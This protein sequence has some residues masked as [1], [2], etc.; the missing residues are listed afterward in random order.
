MSTNIYANSSFS[1]VPLGL[2]LQQTIT[3]T[4]TTSVTI[5]S[6]IKRV[7]AVCIGAG[8]SGGVTH[9]AAQATITNAVGN[10]TT[11]TYTANNSFVVGE[12]VSVA[13][14][15][16]STLNQSGAARIT[17]ASATQFTIAGT[18][19][20]TYTSGGTATSGGAAGGGG[21]GGIS[22]GWTFVD[23]KV[24]VG[25]GGTAIITPA[26]PTTGNAGG[27]SRYGLVIAGGGGGGLATLVTGTF[28][29][30]YAT[31]PGSCSGGNSSIA[32]STLSSPIPPSSYTGMQS[33]SGAG[34]YNPSSTQP[35]VST[36]GGVGVLSRA[37]ANVS[38]TNA[39]SGLICGGGGAASTSAIAT[40]ASGGTGD[41]FSGGTGSSGTGFTFG[42]GGGGAGYFGNGGNASGN[43]AGN[44]GN[45]GGGGGGANNLGT[46]GSGGNGV[47]YLYY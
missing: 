20:G 24:T 31:G 3:T 32:G 39:A 9:I 14:I 15:T 12:N 17:S 25:A 30:I 28:P 10:G 47:V 19:T 16:P 18:Q 22:M 40:G 2:K 43:T 5:P 29:G 23:N 46:S 1:D 27:F 11:V 7:F 35:G 21:A 36:P 44:G 37:G 45:G 13:G 38:A 42:A 6:N 26:E 34:L 41:L 4:G 33:N 8:G